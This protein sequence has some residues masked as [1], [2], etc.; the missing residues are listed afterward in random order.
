MYCNFCGK[1]IQDDANVCAYCGR[2][3]VLGAVPRR[4]LIRP[5]AGRKI[6][7]VCMGFSEYFDVDIS[8][9]RLI[10]LLAAI[11]TFPMGEVTYLVAWIIMPEEPRPLP[12]VAP[13]GDQPNS[14]P[15]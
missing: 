8:L 3:V 13:V 2:R 4:K 15:A 11:V 7:G 5:R 9:V 10:W 14:R 12:M 6:A 1:L